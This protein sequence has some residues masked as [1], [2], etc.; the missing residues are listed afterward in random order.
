MIDTAQNNAATEVTRLGC[1]WRY[2]HVSQTTTGY[3]YPET[4]PVAAHWTH[5]LALIVISHRQGTYAVYLPSIDDATTLP[6][7]ALLSTTLPRVLTYATE[8]ALWLSLPLELYRRRL[9]FAGL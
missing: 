4:L 2:S 6:T 5:W 7:D 8:D 1:V 9:H 3:L